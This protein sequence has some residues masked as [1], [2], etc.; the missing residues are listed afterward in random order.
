M[1]PEVDL[2]VGV[3]GINALWAAGILAEIGPDMSVFPS[4]DQLASW[5]GLCPGSNESAGKRKKTPTRK[6]SHWLR[7]LVVECAWAASRKKGSD[8]M[9]KFHQL[10]ARTNPTLALIAIARKMVVALYHML[11]EHVP[12]K[13]RGADYLPQ[14]Q[15]ERRARRLVRQ[16]NVLGFQVQ[17]VP[18]TT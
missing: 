4:A 17:L 6:G 1:Q 5:A 7:V 16:L 15:P 13:E 11:S 8:W 12:Y 14:D 9:R 10:R 3:P 18:T 2:L